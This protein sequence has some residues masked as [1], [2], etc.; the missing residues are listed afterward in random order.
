M[1]DKKGK[2]IKGFKP[3]SGMFK[4]GYIP[5]NKGKHIWSK[6]ERIKRAKMMTGKNHPMYGKKHSINSRKKM[7]KSH[8]GIQA[9]EKHPNWKGGKSKTTQ[10]YIEQ[11]TVNPKNTRRYRLQHRLII[12]K[13]IGRKLIRR[14][15]VHHIN[16]I[17]TDNRP[18]NLMAFSREPIHKRFERGLS[19]NAKDI[20]FDGRKIKVHLKPPQSG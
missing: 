2:Y 8:I 5:W 4:K 19:V 14:E 12:E 15:S 10:G 3:E 13:I 7:S 6:A 9:R 1:R 17:K 20:I 16:K 18:Q 11:L